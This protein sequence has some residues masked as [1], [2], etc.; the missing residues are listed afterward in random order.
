MNNEEKILRLLES[1]NRK[2]VAIGLH[3]RKETWV[4]AYWLK[5]ATGW[6][7]NQIRAARD[8]GVVITRHNKENSLQY[9]LESIPEMF[10]IK[11]AAP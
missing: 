3:Q 9:L 8:Q 1:I 10:I 6:N 4:S 7:P 11:R 5:E 2:L